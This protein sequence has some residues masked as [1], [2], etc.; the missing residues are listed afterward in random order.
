MLLFSCFDGLARLRLGSSMASSALAR[1][2]EEHL[3]ANRRK[4]A[5]KKYR[6]NADV[7]LNLS[8]LCEEKRK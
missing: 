3:S 7:D 5:G 6:Q 4:E 2:M 8:K 1:Q